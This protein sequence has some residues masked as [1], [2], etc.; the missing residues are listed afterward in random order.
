MGAIC[1]FVSDPL[2][3]PVA[4]VLAPT[5]TSE[6]KADSVALAATGMTVGVPVPVV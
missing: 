4:G 1:T 6:V 5:T 2:T 3:T